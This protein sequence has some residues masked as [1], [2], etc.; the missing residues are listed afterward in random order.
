M[1]HWKTAP[2]LAAI[3]GTGTYEDVLVK[4]ADGW[5]FKKRSFF[6]NKLSPSMV[7]QV[8]KN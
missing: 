7:G 5:R 8:S 2:A 4:T 3:T 1:T 6:A